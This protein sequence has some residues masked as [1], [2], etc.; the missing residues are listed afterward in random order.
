MNPNLDTLPGIKQEAPK[1]LL[2]I[3]LQVSR[4]K[5]LLINANIEV[6]AGFWSASAF[7]NTQLTSDDGLGNGS[8]KPS[9]T[10]PPPLTQTELPHTP[11][12]E[13]AQNPT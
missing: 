11:L 7:Q 9:K 1:L 5:R 8:L 10:L 4:K 2:F 12:P 13:L 6:P 3:V